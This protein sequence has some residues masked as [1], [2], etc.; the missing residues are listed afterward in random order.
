MTNKDKKPRKEIPLPILSSL[1]GLSDADRQL[2]SQAREQAIK[3]LSKR[4]DIS[5]MVAGVLLDAKLAEL[6]AAQQL[7]EQKNNIRQL[8]D[9]C[10]PDDDEE[11]EEKD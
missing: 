3:D 7:R 8:L 11:N 5:E 6:D 9:D 4:H 1:E 10:Y 2:L